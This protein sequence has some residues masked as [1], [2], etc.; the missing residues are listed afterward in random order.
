LSWTSD[1]ITD[2]GSVRGVLKAAGAI[3][4]GQCEVVV[5]G[6]AQ[7]DNKL[8]G[9]AALGTGM[10]YEF[11]DPF[12]VYN[13]PHFAL[14][15]TRHMHQFGTTS[16]QIA[17]VSATVRNNGHTNPEAV[18]FGRGP[19]TIEDVLSSRMIV[20]PFHVLDM[21]MI[22]C[23]GAALVL[24]TAERAA[25]LR[26]P[27][28]LILG[29]AREM[30]RAGYANPPL[31]RE[32]GFLGKKATERALGM[33]GVKVGDLD[34]L[35]LYDPNSFEIMRQLEMLGICGEGESGPFVETGAIALD[36]PY[37]VNPDGGLL[38][39]SWNRLAQQGLKIVEGVRQLRGDACHQVPGAEVAFVTNAGAGA[40]HIEI[41]VLGRG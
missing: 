4:T 31:L 24:T 28:V 21:A 27:P 26:H 34:V 16:E 18:Y 12:G 20:S 13:G 15:A 39:H 14:V 32:V 35:S 2:F 38:S 1:E 23:G 33:A 11:A 5:L 37:P 10:E 29:G 41:M 9:G 19:Y 40:Q 7:A 3:A 8:T 30:I 22:A 17:L 36:G 25:D 6:A